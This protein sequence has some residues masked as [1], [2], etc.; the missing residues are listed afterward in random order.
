MATKIPS[1]QEITITELRS[2]DTEV[3]E[4][5]KQRLSEHWLETPEHIEQNY[6]RPALKNQGF[7]Y[8][9][10]ARYKDVF[11]G[12]ALL[13]VEEKSYLGICHEPWLLGLFVKEDYRGQGIG[14]KLVEAVKEAAKKHGHTYLYLDTAQAAGYYNKLGGWE[15]VGT[16]SW[17]K[18]NLP[19]VIMRTSL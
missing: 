10:L 5:I 15:R 19:L 8:V 13:A 4:F 3:I 6:L 17:E 1:L 7:P 14:A 2:T 18:K 12:K 11:V 16:D 9:F